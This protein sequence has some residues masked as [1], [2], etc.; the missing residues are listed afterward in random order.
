VAGLSWDDPTGRFGGQ[1]IVTRSNGKNASDVDQTCADAFASPS[2]CYLAGGFTVLDLTGY[3]NIT[4]AATLR[5]GVFNLT[6]ETYSWW[7]DVR[8]LDVTNAGRDA[9]T[10]PGIN[11][12]ASI[13]YR[14]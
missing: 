8:G 4:D 2:P 11:A 6:D 5:F 13:S 10:Q 14:F 7:S 9:Y 1:F 3:F 12:S